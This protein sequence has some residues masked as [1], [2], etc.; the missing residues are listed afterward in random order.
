[1]FDI[2]FSSDY[3]VFSDDNN[4]SIALSRYI[5]N[6]NTCLVLPPVNPKRGKQAEHD[7]SIL[8]EF[9]QRSGY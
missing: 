7:S 5:D 6:D 8:I 9:I 1:M 4:I 2:M 3:A